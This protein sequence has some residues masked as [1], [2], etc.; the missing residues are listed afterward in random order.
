MFTSP[1]TAFL[2]VSVL[3]ALS[4]VFMTFVWYGHLKFKTAPIII[5]LF[6]SWGLAF[7]EY[8]FQ[9]PANRYGHAY[10]SAAHLKTIQ[11][12]LS[13]SIFIAFSYF[14]LGESLR[15]GQVLG[16][17]MIVLGACLVFQKWF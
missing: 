8:C 9:I 3:L 5:V 13:I 17:G 16:F 2:S 7:F 15:L 12:V 14:Y 10:L 1:L 6:I 4:N 11:E